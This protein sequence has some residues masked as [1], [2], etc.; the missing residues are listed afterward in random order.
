MYYTVKMSVLIQNLSQIFIK[1]NKNMTF[2]IFYNTGKL[3]VNT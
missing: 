1:Y 2:F 3:F